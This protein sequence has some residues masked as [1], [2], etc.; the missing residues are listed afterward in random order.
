MEQLLTIFRFS[1]TGGA[2]M[3]D[4]RARVFAWEEGMGWIVRLIDTDLAG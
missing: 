3:V 2:A 4:D 1:A